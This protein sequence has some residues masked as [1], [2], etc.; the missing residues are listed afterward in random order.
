MFIRGQVGE[1]F[2]VRNSGAS[3]VVEGV[4]DHGCEYMTGGEVVVLGATGR[5]FAAGMSGGVAYVLDLDLGRVNTEMVDLEPVDAAAAEAVR[6]LIVQHLEE[7]ESPVAETLRADWPTSA[8]RFTT[9]MPRDY[10]AALKARADAERAGLTEAE[11][12]AKMMEAA[13]G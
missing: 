1:R 3:L 8:D 11:T 6:T 7:T 12:T 10:R 9:V 5:N 13:H 4:G 2:A